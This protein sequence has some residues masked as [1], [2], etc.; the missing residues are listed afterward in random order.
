MA[1][2]FRLGYLIRLDADQMRVELADGRTLGTLLARFP[3]LFHSTAEQ[4]ADVR[5]SPNG[6]RSEALD[7]DISIV[8]LLAG[9]GDQA[10]ARKTVA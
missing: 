2:L 5:I 4:R 10:T 7:E 6:L 8:G 1:L 9:R 3:R